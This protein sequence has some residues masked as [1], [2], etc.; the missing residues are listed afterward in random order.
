MH[1]TQPIGLRAAGQVG[2]WSSFGPLF[3]CQSQWL[4]GLGLQETLWDTRQVGPGL[5][6]V[7]EGSSMLILIAGSRM[8]FAIKTQNF[9][10]IVRE[11]VTVAVAVG[12]GFEVEVAK[13]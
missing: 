12:V 13:N 9:S 2:H 5:G 4:F 11:A 1:L 8:Q 6:L 7:L 3:A 10:L